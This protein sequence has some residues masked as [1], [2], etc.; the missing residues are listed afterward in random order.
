MS[1]LTGIE[2]AAFDSD[3]WASVLLTFPFSASAKGEAA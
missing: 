3:D 1:V 2:A